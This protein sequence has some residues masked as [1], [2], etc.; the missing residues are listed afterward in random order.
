[1]APQAGA[2]AKVADSVRFCRAGVARP[3]PGGFHST[4]VGGSTSRPGAPLVPQSS[5]LAPSRR[6]R[7]RNQG[8]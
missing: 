1:M 3:R 6:A 8:L 2:V 4:A 5:S 7:F